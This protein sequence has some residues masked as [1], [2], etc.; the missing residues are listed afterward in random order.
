MK[1]PSLA[2]HAAAGL[3]LAAC[4]SP[5]L[6]STSLSMKFGDALYDVGA[7][8]DGLISRSGSRVSADGAAA[9]GTATVDNGLIRLTMAADGVSGGNNASGIVE[10]SFNDRFRIFD[11][12]VPNGTFGTAT[13]AIAVSGS[14]TGGD[15]ASAVWTLDAT[16]NSSRVFELQGNHDNSDPF[17]DDAFGLYT[18]S[19]RFRF[20]QLQ[21]VSVS[22]S[23]F[24]NSFNGSTRNPGHGACDLGHTIT[25][26]GLTSIVADGGLTLAGPTLSSDSGTNYLLPYTPAAAVPEP[27]AWVLMLAGLAA[28]GG[29]SRRRRERAA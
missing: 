13:F 6:A 1:H 27:G 25:W 18:A 21:N 9:T 19:F 5:A 8:G 28:V 22:A 7:I 4:A 15:R 2:W 16:V 3:L 26:E 14:L 11:A 17:R 12:A 24:A 10:G 20:G 29:V 23:C